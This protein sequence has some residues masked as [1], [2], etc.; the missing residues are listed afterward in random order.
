M[1][2][3]QR[4]KTLDGFKSGKIKVLVATDVAGRGI[5]IDGISHVVNLT[6]P[7]EPEDYVHRIG[8]TGRAGKL[9][10][11]ISF[12]CEDDALKMMPIQE[13]VGDDLKCTQPPGELLAEPPYVEMPKQNRQRR[14]GGNRSGGRPGGNRNG[15]RSG[16]NRSR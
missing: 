15:G 13:L 4:V 5:H 11:S 6:L 12:A 9:G 1:N 7:E 14:P 2:Q 8:R 16:G 3:N 10:T